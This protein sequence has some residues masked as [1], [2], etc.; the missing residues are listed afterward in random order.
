[1]YAPATV[2][3]RM[4]HGSVV[5]EP[6]LAVH[7]V[8]PA[9]DELADKQTDDDEVGHGEELKSLL[10]PAPAQAQCDDDDDDDR[11][12]DARPPS[13]MAMAL[14]QLNEPSLF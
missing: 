2:V 11:P 6:R 14:L 9:A 7:E 8:A 10:A 12:V 3:R 13:Q 5:S 1:M 4:R